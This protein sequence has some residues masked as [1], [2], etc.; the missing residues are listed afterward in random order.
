MRTISELTEFGIPKW[1]SDQLRPL[2]LPKDFIAARLRSNQLQLSNHCNP[3][4]KPTN[5][6]LASPPASEAAEFMS[7]LVEIFRSGAYS[8]HDKGDVFDILD[9]EDDVKLVAGDD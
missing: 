9:T 7:G 3:H 4:A 1:L 6:R 8:R 2:T 5:T